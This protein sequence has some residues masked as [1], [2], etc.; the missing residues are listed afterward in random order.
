MPGSRAWH[1][2]RKPKPTPGRR[3]RRETSMAEANVRRHG[4]GHPEP[5][6][7]SSYR[8]G[9]EHIRAG[10]VGIRS[11]ILSK[12]TGELAGGGFP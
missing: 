6:T 8:P 5:W 4:V 12:T 11:K 9:G 2:D 7:Q 10:G 3:R 1:G